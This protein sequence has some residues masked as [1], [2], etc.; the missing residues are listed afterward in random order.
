[1][2]G[3]SDG[4]PRQTQDKSRSSDF[5]L[6]APSETVPTPFHG[7]VEMVPAVIPCISTT[8]TIQRLSVPEPYSL[9]DRTI[10]VTVD[11]INFNVVFSHR[12]W[13]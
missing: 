8:V 9:T 12:Y 6:G 11:P 1:M 2:N 7:A 5:A 3:S 10:P 4:K 13:A